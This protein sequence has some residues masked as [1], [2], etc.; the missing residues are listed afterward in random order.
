MRCKKV[1][2]VGT[3]AGLLLTDATATARLDAAPTAAQSLGR[4]GFGRASAA[5]AAERW[6]TFSADI[7][8]RHSR[9]K[10]DGLPAGG[11]TPAVRY[12]WERRLTGA[13]WKSTMTFETEAPVSVQSP[14]GRKQIEN[15][16]AVA[17]IE[18]DEDG[19]PLR[20]F[21]RKGERLRVPS[22]PQLRRQ[23]NR[24]PG[25][26]L[27]N[28]TAL[29]NAVRPRTFGREWSEAILAI[30]SKA[31]ARR[32]AL[33]RR[34]GRAA[35]RVRA[36]DRFVST[37]D[38]ETTEVLADPQSALPLEINVVRTQALVSHTTM[39][40]VRGEGGTLI[41]RS[42]HIERAIPDT[43]GERTATDVE[44]NNVRLEEKR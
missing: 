34:F 3:L 9:V 35:G 31:G 40:Y 10:P 23:F 39:G 15:P 17:R 43:A 12:R 42:L 16:F 21:D 24:A 36:L 8:I 28:E 30:P 1:L 13:G 4:E 32:A 27:A 41:R 26:L 25:P 11:A 14:G 29:A 19:T 44:I 37:R 20:L 18:D 5:P 38:Q 6:N 2:G 33:E 7:T 22:E